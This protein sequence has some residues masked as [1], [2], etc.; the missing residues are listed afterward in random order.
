M[1]HILFPPKLPSRCL[2]L[3]PVLQ[4]FD[5]SVGVSHLYGQFDLLSFFH[6]IGRVQILQEGCWFRGTHTHHI[7]KVLHTH[8]HTHD[9]R[10]VELTHTH[11]MLDQ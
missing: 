6:L 11:K 10:S 3:L 4:P 9:V 8:T 1:G 5:V 2:D 7:S